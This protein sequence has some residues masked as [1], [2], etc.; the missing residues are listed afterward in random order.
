MW[1]PPLGGAVPFPASRSPCLTTL[2]PPGAPSATQAESGPDP[3]R[4]GS[5]PDPGFARW[6]EA[7]PSS[8]S[9][10]PCTATPSARPGPMPSPTL[11]PTPRTLATRSSPRQGP[12]P[13]PGPRPR[14]IVRPFVRRLYAA[15][16]PGP[17]LPP[18]PPP[19]P[20][21]TKGAGA[22]YFSPLHGSS[23]PCLR[24]GRPTLRRPSVHTLLDCTVSPGSASSPPLS[25]PPGEQRSTGPWPSARACASR[26][27]LPNR[28]S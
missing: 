5:L 27:S 6:G 20:A 3:T 14:S 13:G 8:A 7:G 18:P 16:G 21:P 22:G 15:S 17:R 23:R 2:S 24:A 4:V 1:A 26:H 19:P 12:G 11:R 10:G 28:L 25:M 9:L